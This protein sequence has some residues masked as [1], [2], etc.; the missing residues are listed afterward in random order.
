MDGNP[1][2]L[3]TPFVRQG[4]VWFV[5]F[6]LPEASQKTAREKVLNRTPVHEL[7]LRVLIARLYEVVSF[8][9]EFVND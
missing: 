3:C 7:L 2:F 8:G 6:V 9:H 4:L 5:K 1:S